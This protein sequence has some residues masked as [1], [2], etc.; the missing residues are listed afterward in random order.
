MSSG[1]ASEVKLEIGHV[2]FIDIVGYSQLLITQQSEQIETLRRIVRGTAQFR[3]AEAEGK[4]L[5]LPT[6]DGGA[7][8][9]RTTPESPVLCALEIAKELRKHPELRVRM[10]IHSGP[11]NAITDLNEQSNI[12]GAG[13]NIAQRVMDCGDAGHIL[14]SKHVAEDLEHYPRWQP[15]LHDLGECEVKHGV[16]VS[17]VNFYT[18]E[19]GNP[20]L[21][22]KFKA[23]RPVVTKPETKRAKPIFP[24]AIGIAA[25]AGI[26]ILAALM[27]PSILRSRE[28]AKTDRA[29]VLPGVAKSIAVLPFENLS[30]DPDNAYFVEGIQDEILT[31]LSKVADLKV[32]SR[33]STQKYK[34]APD[35]LRDVARQLG[36]ANI[37]EGSVQKIANVVHVN[38]QLIRAA[39][40]EHLWAESYNRTLNDVF[41]VEGEVASAIAEQLNAK[42]TG[43]E[44]KAVAA[45]PTQNPAAYD[46][47]LRGLSLEHNEYSYGAYLQ[48][49]TDYAEAVRLDPNFA[50]AWAR[51][52]SIRSFL[53]FNRIE[54]NTNTA[55]A[56]KEAADRA[57]AL[58]PEAGE[59]WIAQG[60]YR[61]R[62]QRDFSGALAAYEEAQKRLPNNALVYE[63]M[64]YV[65][66][67][68]GRWQE[69]EANYKKAL[70]LD[71]RDIQLLSSM[72]NEFYNYL[73]RFDDALAMLNRALE[74]SPDSEQ[75][76]AN[77]ANVLLAAGRLR[78][79]AEELDH[80]PANSTED[81][82]VAVR[83]VQ[84]LYERQYDTAIQIAERR[85][86]ATAAGQPLDAFAISALADAG[87]C[88]A[89]T[90]RPDEARR[91]FTR[92]IN[93]LQ[94]TP[95]T[96]VPADANGSPILPAQAYAG[97]GEKELALKQAQQALKEYETD[98]IGK[99]QTEV[100]VAQIQAQLGDREA[101][102][103]ALPHLLEA[104][105]GVTTA[106]L[107]FNPF[108][109]PLRKDPRFQK[110]CEETS[111]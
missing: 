97:V 95:D 50:L 49:A 52:A 55:V 58:A 26:A 64:A 88:Y 109:D 10:G 94:P 35:N 53:Y 106:D 59:S 72:G 3:E 36:V 38:V 41:G 30:R 45:K 42:L 7:L 14:V 83:I 74:I 84:A 5:R 56:V 12:A 66:R 57:M 47:Y 101:A 46:A 89:W 4:L 16:R 60:A 67:R 32:I 104:P 96:V 39:T 99:A 23:A 103:A 91:A 15:Y 28:N 40:D 17:V 27:L 110:L 108:W 29:E 75:S 48:V 111:K 77:K 90:R 69:A 73:R 20:A 24:I 2:L 92:V 86:N 34:S 93:E 6:G 76:R 51:L 85:M 33:T 63:Y 22:D 78:E 54:A 100:V 105:A 81:W 65:Q 79:A 80:I 87:Y 1:P 102:I 8:V 13:I 71:P 9:F 82:V 68:L 44:Q 18:D 98:A 11:V 107:K 21:P 25:I 61:Y 70:Q 37:L 62:V 31:R 43:T 19:V